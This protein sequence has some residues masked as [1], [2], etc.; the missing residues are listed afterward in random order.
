MEQLRSMKVAF[1]LKT[2]SGWAVL[3]VLGDQRHELTVVDRRVTLR[4]A[5]LT[6]AATRVCRDA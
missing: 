2:H 3:V 5:F 4:R 1:G 6:C